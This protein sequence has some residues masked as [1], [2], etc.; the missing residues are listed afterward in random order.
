MKIFGLKSSEFISVEISSDQSKFVLEVN[1]EKVS[2]CGVYNA[3]LVFGDE[4]EP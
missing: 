4:H 3:T 2:E 1:R